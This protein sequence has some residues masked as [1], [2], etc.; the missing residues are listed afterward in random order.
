MNELD[1]TILG[2]IINERDE[3]YVDTHRKRGEWPINICMNNPKQL[4]AFVSL[5][6]PNHGGQFTLNAIYTGI[7]I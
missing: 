7:K 5:D 1:K 6:I 2:I 4:G 3:I